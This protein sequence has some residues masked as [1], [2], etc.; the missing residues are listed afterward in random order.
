M[1]S[2]PLPISLLPPHQMQWKRATKLSPNFKLGEFIK[3]N[4]PMPDDIILW[5]L[6][7]LAQRLQA[8]RDIL[9]RPITITSGFRT[10]EQNKAI[11]GHP[12]S[13]HLRGMA[14]D[15]VVASLTPKQVQ[16]KLAQWQ[17]GLGCYPTFTHIDIGPKRRF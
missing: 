2:A 1:P 17:G 15:I 5:N 11:G 12:L 3:P 16:Q 14:A 8:L 4:T 6:W 9:N 10:P 7:L 13:Y